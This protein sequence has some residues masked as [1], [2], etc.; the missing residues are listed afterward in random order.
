ML[1]ELAPVVFL[2]VKG[3]KSYVDEYLQDSMGDEDEEKPKMAYEKASDRWEVAVTVSDKGFQHVSFVNSI[4][5]T[6]V[7]MSG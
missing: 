1:A 5:T 7:R 3:F 6:K 4:A 2:Q